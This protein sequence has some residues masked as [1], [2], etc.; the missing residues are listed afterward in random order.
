MDNENTQKQIG[1]IDLIKQ[2]NGAM[3]YRVI[4]QHGPISRIQ[5]A[6]KSQLAPASVTKITRH[7]L[8]RGLI[9]EGLTQMKALSVICHISK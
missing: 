4:D 8:E 2:L 3:V 9:K 1:N 5:I 7:L 6:E